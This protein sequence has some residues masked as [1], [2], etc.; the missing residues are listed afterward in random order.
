LEGI[1]RFA[2][3]AREDGYTEAEILRAAGYE[4]PANV[5]LRETVEHVLRHGR[6][7]PRRQRDRLRSALRLVHSAE[8][9]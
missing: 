1:R 6:G 4:R 8:A 2:E 7:V 9:A 3:F 5:E